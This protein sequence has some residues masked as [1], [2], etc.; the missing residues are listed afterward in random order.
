MD[1]YNEVVYKIALYSIIIGGVTGSLVENL[2]NHTFNNEYF[3]SI[4]GKKIKKT[5]IPY[6]AVP[7]GTALGIIAPAFP[8]VQIDTGGIELQWWGYLIGGFIGGMLSIAG[9]EMFKSI[10]IKK[11]G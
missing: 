8:F 10:F 5:V 11:G 9:Y 4:K 1:M 2:K 3:P 7:L 6:I